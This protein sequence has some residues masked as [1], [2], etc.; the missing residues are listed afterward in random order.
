MENN[1]IFDEVTFYGVCVDEIKE[2]VRERMEADGLCDFDDDVIMISR[3]DIDYYD[4][5]INAIRWGECFFDDDMLN[6]ILQDCI[7][8]YPHYLVFAENCTWD[9]RSGYRFFKDV[10]E[11]LARSYEINFCI[12]YT[13]S[14][15]VIIGIESS[16]DCPM[17]HYTYIIGLTEKQYEKL[18]YSNF[19]K[20]SNFIDQKV[21]KIKK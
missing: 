17:G 8:N 5:D 20:I 18:Y 9:G 16:H 12:D 11:T 19:E 3:A 6:E 13:N 21:K 10:T 14:K 7:G 15:D 2:D 1:N 4:I